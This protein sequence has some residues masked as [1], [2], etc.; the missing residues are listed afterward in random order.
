MVQ[1]GSFSSTATCSLRRICYSS[2]HILDLVCNL[3]RLAS[4]CAVVDS[5]G[6]WRGCNGLAVQ[7]LDAAGAGLVAVARART[8]ATTRVTTR[9]RASERV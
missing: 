9:S 1:S 3:L 8:L 2:T 7:R 6:L 5:K 4:C